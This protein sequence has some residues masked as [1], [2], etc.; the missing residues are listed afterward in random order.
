MTPSTKPHPASSL[1]HHT[2]PSGGTISFSQLWLNALDRFTR[3]TGVDPLK[4]K[5]AHSFSDVQSLDQVF[6]MVETHMK[7]FKAFRAP[8]SRWDELREKYF[9]PIVRALLVVT[10]A[11]GELASD[12]VRIL[13]VLKYSILNKIQQVPG[14]KTIFVVFAILLQVCAASC[15]R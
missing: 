11:A 3:K 9:K 6:A 1:F 7:D 2:M 12:L 5:L 15:Q 8:G 14:G 4:H 10:E 13:D